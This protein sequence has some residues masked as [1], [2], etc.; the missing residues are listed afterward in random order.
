MMNIVIRKG[1]VTDLTQ[2][3]DLIKELAVYEKE[4]DA[5]MI[6][7]DDL[8]K[9]AFGSDKIFDF[10]VAKEDS[11]V[12]GVAIYYYRYST[13]EGKSIYLEDLVVNE[14]CR[15]QGIGAML[16]SALI[17]KSKELKVHRLEWQVLN[18]NTPAINFYKKYNAGL[19]ENWTNGRLVFDQI[20]NFKKK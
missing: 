10:F 17:D 1:V 2:V 14:Q 15:G 8:E 19:D 6:N 16:F 12:L 11:K 20:Q 4:P 9:H 3:L 5:V 13:W 18:W 7:V